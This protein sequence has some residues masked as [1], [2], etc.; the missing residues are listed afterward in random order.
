MVKFLG[1]L[2][3]SLVTFWGIGFLYFVYTLPTV[4]S[5]NITKTDAIVVWTGGGCRIATGLELLSK[6]MSDQLFISGVYREGEVTNGKN[7]N[8]TVDL[9]PEK[10]LV[11]PED[12]CQPEDAFDAFFNDQEKSLGINRKKGKL[13]KVFQKSCHDCGVDLT[14]E[15]IDQLLQKTFVGHLA[16]TTIGNAIETA[17]WV[18][19]NKIHSIRLV[20]SPMHIPRSLAECRRYLSGIQVIMHPVEI[21]KFNH[22]HWY[23]DW[24]ITYKV[25][26]EYSKYLSILLGVRIQ[27][28]ENLYS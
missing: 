2:V 24:R 18:R 22:H 11:C 19:K 25:A 15:Q 4:P 9:L 13:L 28:Q 23:K 1:A 16:K 7:K 27:R 14:Y 20:T 8:L 21:S 6:R 17:R 26:I 5:D 12:M 10:L 3:L